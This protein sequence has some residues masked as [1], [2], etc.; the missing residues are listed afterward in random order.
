MPRSLPNQQTHRMPQQNNLQHQS[1]VRLDEPWGVFLSSASSPS[2]ITIYP[3]SKPALQSPAP[4][5]CANICL[6]GNHCPG[7]AMI[8]P[9]LRL[10]KVE[11]L[12]CKMPSYPILRISSPKNKLQGTIPMCWPYPCFSV[13]QAKPC[14]FLDANVGQLQGSCSCFLLGKHRSRPQGSSTS[15]LCGCCCCCCCRVPIPISNFR[16]RI[17]FSASDMR[18]LSP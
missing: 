7:R 12:L 1:E 9:H 17:I 11:I 16:F 6:H 4:Q 13:S 2:S 8:D 3:S 15:R 18:P 10:A 14:G 5:C